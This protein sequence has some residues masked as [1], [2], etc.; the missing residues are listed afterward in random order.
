MSLYIE[1]IMIMMI[2]ITNLIILLVMWVYISRE[3]KKIK[4]RLDNIE[5]KIDEIRVYTIKRK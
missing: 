3:I 5:N 1:F 4:F 2:G